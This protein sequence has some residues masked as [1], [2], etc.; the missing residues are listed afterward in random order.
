MNNKFGIELTD[1]E[2]MKI[3]GGSKATRNAGRAFGFVA[4]TTLKVLLTC[5]I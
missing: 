4:G 3:N 5:P 2:L 1:N